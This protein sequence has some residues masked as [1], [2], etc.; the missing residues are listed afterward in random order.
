MRSSAALFH[1]AHALGHDRLEQTG[2]DRPVGQRPSRR[3]AGRPIQPRDQ[4]AA[5]FIEQAH[6]HHGPAFDRRLQAAELID[7][8]SQSPK[9][10]RN[11]GKVGG[12]LLGSCQRRI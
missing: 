6:R 12:P 10:G 8:S 1:L 3:S 4:L 5:Q 2:S 9:L 11:E 7:R